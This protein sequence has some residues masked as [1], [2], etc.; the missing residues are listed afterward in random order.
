MILCV[1]RYTLNGHRPGTP[2]LIGGELLSNS[3]TPEVSVTF[4]YLGR[5]LDS[6]ESS[7]IKE[8]TRRSTLVSDP[9]GTVSLISSSRV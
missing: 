2:S 5:L 3:S 6:L 7:P 8:S 9:S 1:C 4:L